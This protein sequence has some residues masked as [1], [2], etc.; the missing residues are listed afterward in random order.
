MK[1]K[2][3]KPTIWNQKLTFKN[4]FIFVKS[5]L[6]SALLVMLINSTLIQAS[7]VPTGSM[8]N[9]I[10]TGDFL[11]IN[12][13]LYGPSTPQFIPFT[14]IELPYIQFPG[15]KDPKLNEVIVFRFP[16][17]RDE[18]KAEKIDYYVKRCVGTPGD[19]IQVI[20]KVLY[21]NGKQFPIPPNIKYERWEIYPPYFTDPGLFPVG[22][23]WN[24]DNYGPIIVP[25]KGDVIKLSTDNIE[26]WATFINREYGE[27]VVNVAGDEILIDGKPVESYTVQ[28]DCYFMMGDNRDN[29]LDSRSW[30]F[31][32]RKNIAGSPLIVFWSW[33]PSIPFTAPIKLLNSVRLDR[34]A[35]LVD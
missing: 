28:N 10:M 34:I 5:V 12:K 33:D 31:V 3:A 11:F 17:N 27:A 15:I 26:K 24:C 20:N 8:E 25:K 14:N 22:S 18:I 2:I 16:G 35:K 6:S 29:S 1:K 30:G 21:V 19:T 9:T 7:R 13:F 4:I 32:P 23:N